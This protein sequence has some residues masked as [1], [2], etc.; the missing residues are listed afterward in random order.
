MRAWA[1]IFRAIL[2]SSPEIRCGQADLVRFQPNDVYVAILAVRRSK[3]WRYAEMVYLY[4][5]GHSGDKL[6]TFWD[7]IEADADGDALG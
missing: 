1:T 6:H 5:R 4:G 2:P 3:T 7:P